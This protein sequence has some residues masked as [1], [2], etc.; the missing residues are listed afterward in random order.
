MPI[1]GYSVGR[2]LTLTIMVNGAPI[3]FRGITG[4]RKKQD[5]DETKI[6]KIDG[7]TDHVIFQKGWSGSFDLE[8][9]SA[10]LDIYFAQVEQDYYSGIT[11]LPA[12]IHETIQEVNRSITQWALTKVLLKYDDA[13]DWTGDKTIKQAVSFLATR[14]IRTA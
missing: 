2:D 14:R 9:Q 10:D 5:V 8:R 7:V 11:A 4:F 13:G 1:N 12:S 3:R 6:V